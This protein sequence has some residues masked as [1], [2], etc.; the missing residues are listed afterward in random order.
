MMGPGP[1][2]MMG[3]GSGPPMMGPGPGPPMMGPGHGPPMMGPGPGPGPP[4]MCAGPGPQFGNAPPPHAAA[5]GAAPP[6][7]IRDMEGYLMKASRHSGGW[8]LR[9]VKLH[10]CT[11]TFH[12]EQEQ[13]GHVDLH[14][15]MQV[16][17]FSNPSAS[18]S[19]KRYQHDHPAGFEL[20]CGLRERSWFFDAS[21]PDKQRVWLSAVSN[22]IR[23]SPPGVLAELREKEAAN[24]AEHG[25]NSE[26]SQLLHKL[27]SHQ[28]IYDES[29]KDQQITVAKELMVLLEEA[30]NEAERL[31]SSIKE[32]QEEQASIQQAMPP[33]VARN[34][35]ISQLLPQKKAERDRIE[36]EKKAAESRYMKMLEAE[37]T[38]VHVMRK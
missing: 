15:S 31:K 16:R 27:S 10:G 33:L 23:S 34:S 30:Q 3:P 37:P 5:G 9:M 1:G 11:I 29:Q 21:M 8:R 25:R 32:M 35:E 19:A 22:A 24:G 2:P 28:L 38:L 14:N 26:A 20:H 36:H 6:P 4:M 17:E 13:T 18:P 12:K 7:Q